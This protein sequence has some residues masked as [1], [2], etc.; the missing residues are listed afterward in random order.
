MVEMD[1]WMS[2]TQW[3]R[4]WRRYWTIS[5][6]CEWQISQINPFPFDISKVFG[7]SFWRGGKNYQC[8]ISLI[9]AG[10]NPSGATNPSGRSKQRRKKQTLSLSPT[11]LGQEIATKAKKQKDLPTSWSA[12]MP[13]LTIHES[14]YSSKLGPTKKKNCSSK[15]L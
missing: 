9:Y 6:R 5:R 1:G 12:S 2:A 7:A 15:R 8:S 3:M 4:Y 11:L 13:G 10:F 14:V